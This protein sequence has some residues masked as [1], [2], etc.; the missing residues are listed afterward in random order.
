MAI[1]PASTDEGPK[2]TSTNSLNM[3]WI[4]GPAA[5]II[6]IQSIGAAF[7]GYYTW[8]FG[9]WSVLPEPWNYGLLVAALLLLF[10]VSRFWKLSAGLDS[11][12]GSRPAAFGSIT[13]GAA[14]AFLLALFFF[15]RSRA[16]LYGDGY[17]ILDELGGTG[18][19]STGF[20]I[21]VK[22]L[23]YYLYKW[24]CDALSVT[25]TLSVEHSFAMVSAAGGVIGTVALWKIA[26]ILSSHSV[27]RWF[28]FLSALTSGCVILFFGYIE[29]YTLAT[30]S[31]LWTIYYTLR[32]VQGKSGPVPAILLGLLTTGFHIL[33]LPYLLFAVLAVALHRA[34][35]PETISGR[36]KR[37]SLLAV[38]ASVLLGLL[39][40]VLSLPQ[41]L[42]LIW[43]R[44]DVPYWFLSPDRLMD[45]LN[46][47][48]LV[49]PL[50]LAVLAIWIFS[51]KGKPTI[52][53]SLLGSL[54][55]LC[56]LVAFWVEPKLG[57]ARDWDLASFYGFPFTLW[58][59]AWLTNY[60]LRPLKH[61]AAIISVAVLLLVLIAPNLIEKNNLAHA[62]RYLDRALRDSPHHRADYGLARRA[63]IW[64]FILNDKAD[65]PELAIPN[66]KRRL[67]AEPN[68]PDAWALLG[69]I[70]SDKSMLDS[71]ALYFSGATL[72]APGNAAYLTRLAETECRLGR[73]R[74]AL[75][76]IVIAERLKP[77]LFE[78]QFQFGVVLTQLERY[79]EAVGRFRKAIALDPSVGAAVINLGFLYSEL[80][81]HDSA[82]V[83]LSRALEFDSKNK[84][85]YTKLIKADLALSRLQEAQQVLERYRLINPN[86]PDIEYFMGTSAP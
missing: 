81:Q 12:A 69:T 28:I 67:D 52:E 78:A 13:F 51:K 32:H 59:A 72:Y 18:P 68:T 65:E 6:I 56:F 10:A 63:W 31:G 23:S 29:Y 47:T 54:A 44:D 62:A 3:G 35:N 74:S 27:Q 4:V 73:Y 34:G 9:Y 15:F 1:V 84:H 26:D 30:A 86:A 14:V 46:L 85:L 70:Y 57:A 76:H 42:M 11:P 50:G 21:Y 8:G 20:P 55:L 82:R 61:P 75:E 79:A 37:I 7:P 48:L 49:A 40:Q 22:G 39:A 36:L 45:L 25:F 17:L 80:K 2:Q 33:A 58:A 41:W 43:P 60:R 19:E 64:A 71:A 77:D 16:H 5:F 66:L 53:G 24:F 83:Y 38:G